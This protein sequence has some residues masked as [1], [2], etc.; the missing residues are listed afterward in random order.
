MTI[1]TYDD[2]TH[3]AVPFEPTEGMLL[4]ATKCVTDAGFK[5]YRSQWAAMIAAAPEHETVQ[6]EPVAWMRTIKFEDGGE[7]VIVALSDIYADSV[8]LYTSPQPYLAD[9]RWKPISTLPEG[10]APVLLYYRKY[11]VIEANARY[12]MEPKGSGWLPIAWK[13][14]P[15]NSSEVEAE[16]SGDYTEP[17][18]LA[19]KVAE[20]EK[21]LAKERGQVEVMRQLL[22]R[23]GKS[24][25]PEFLE[26]RSTITKQAEKIKMACDTLLMIRDGYGLYGKELAECNRAIDKLTASL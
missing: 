9:T 6:Q 3:V 4:A 18:D 12:A 26:L 21:E 10:D 7:D 17:T 1:K 15:K 14:A 23:K 16:I 22:M 20:L 13:L 24:V 11:G 25:M 5:W 19:A 2:T 8:P